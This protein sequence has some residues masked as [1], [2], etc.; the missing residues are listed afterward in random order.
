MGQLDMLSAP[1]GSGP[2]EGSTPLDAAELYREAAVTVLREWNEE[3]SSSESN[4]LQR[5][6]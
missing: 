2:V 1:G 3:K 4:A 5:L 6:V